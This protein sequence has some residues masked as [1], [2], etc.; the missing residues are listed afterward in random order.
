MCQDGKT[1]RDVS[2]RWTMRWRDGGEQDQEREDDIHKT[3]CHDG[4]GHAMRCEAT[5]TDGKGFDVTT[6]SC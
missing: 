3:H 5:V 6:C 4:G 1:E 2:G